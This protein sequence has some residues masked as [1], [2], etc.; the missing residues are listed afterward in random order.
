MV[1]S[2]AATP[3]L[4]LSRRLCHEQIQLQS[5]PLELAAEAGKDDWD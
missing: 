5:T 2:G 1:E 3:I 4:M